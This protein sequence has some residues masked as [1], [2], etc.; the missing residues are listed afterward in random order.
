MREDQ[1]DEKEELV[2]TEWAL[3]EHIS[4]QE[5]A[6]VGQRVGMAQVGKPDSCWVGS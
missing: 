2:W 1:R 5:G 6:S 3:T 4:A